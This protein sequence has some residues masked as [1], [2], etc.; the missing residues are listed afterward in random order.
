MSDGIPITPEVNDPYFAI[1]FVNN[2]PVRLV[3]WLRFAEDW[4]ATPDIGPGARTGYIPALEGPTVEWKCLY[5][6]SLAVR[7]SLSGT[8][9]TI[10]DEGALEGED[11][12]TWQG[13]FTVTYGMLGRTTYLQLF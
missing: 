5:E 4:Y 2:L 1:A 12:V 3:V 6:G 13:H 9:W 11:N 10:R 7:N 8:A